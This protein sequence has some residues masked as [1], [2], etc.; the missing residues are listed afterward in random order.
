MNLIT[1]L[2]PET[3]AAAILTRRVG[4]SV[5]KWRAFLEQ[6]RKRIA[7]NELPRV[8][9]EGEIEDPSYYEDGVYEFARLIERKR[10]GE[11]VPPQPPHWI[12]TGCNAAADFDH[13]HERPA[14]HIWV[15]GGSKQASARLPL[16]A[17]KEF[18]DEVSRI[19]QQLEPRSNGELLALYRSVSDGGRNG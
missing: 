14:V 11:Y 1:H 19:I 6:D 7:L 8:P 15:Y 9:F 13:D 10:G 18:V 3:R 12:P 17:A 5:E 2:I 16:Q 4:G